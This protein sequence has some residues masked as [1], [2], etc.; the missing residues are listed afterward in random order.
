MHCEVCQPDVVTYW[1]NGLT[2]QV[3]RYLVKE[4]ARNN[5]DKTVEL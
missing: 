3:V 2:S 1:N 4:R 5:L